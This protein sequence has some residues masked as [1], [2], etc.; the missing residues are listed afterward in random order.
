MAGHSLTSREFSFRYLS[1]IT[2]TC[3]PVLSRTED[4]LLLSN[5]LI[6]HFFIF[7]NSRMSLLTCLVIISTAERINVA[8]ARITNLIIHF[9]WP[10]L[11]DLIMTHTHAHISYVAYPE[12]SSFLFLWLKISWLQRQDSH[13]IHYFLLMTKSLVSHTNLTIL[14]LEKNKKA[15]WPVPYHT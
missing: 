12:L 2:E 9:C 5:A 1:L 6:R 10:D 15:S 8:R 7:R 3:A 13:Q 14:F 4:S 11:L